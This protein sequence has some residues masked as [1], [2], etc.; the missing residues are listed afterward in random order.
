MFDKDNLE[1]DFQRLIYQKPYKFVAGSNLVQKFDHWVFGEYKTESTNL[2]KILT[3]TKN[4]KGAVPLKVVGNL[5]LLRSD[6]LIFLYEKIKGR[7]IIIV[8]RYRC[9]FLYLYMYLYL[10]LYF[11][12]DIW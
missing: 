9:T 5:H 4:M 11:V 7:Q 2:T 12:P 3:K 1:I 10:Y 8:I 6:E